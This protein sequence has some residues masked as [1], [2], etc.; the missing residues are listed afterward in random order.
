MHEL[1]LLATVFLAVMAA[2]VWL[3]GAGRCLARPAQTARM[4]DRA[5]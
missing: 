1:F 4:T 3:G 2:T 5:R